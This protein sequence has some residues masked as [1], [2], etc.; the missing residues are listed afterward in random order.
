MSKEVVTVRGKPFQSKLAP[1]ESEIRELL[2]NE[3]KSTREISREM[4][5]RHQL[6]VSHNSVSSFIKTHKLS[7]RS[8]L[9]DVPAAKRGE[10]L[11]A[12]KAIW[13]HDSTAIEGNTLTIGD[14]MIVLKYGLTIN[15]KPLKD[16]QDVVSHANAVDLISKLVEKPKLEINDLFALHRLVIGEIPH[17]I[18]KPV[19]DFKREINGTYGEYK[20]KSV[21][22]AYAE[23]DETPKLMESWLIK[24]N[25]LLA[26]DLTEE[27]VLDAYLF[28]HTAFVR[29]HPFYDGNGRIARLI[30]NLPV[31]KAGFPPIVIASESRVNY[32]RSL[33]D[34]QH[35]VGVISLKNA[36]MLPSTPSLAAFRELVKASWAS[37][38]SL[39]SEASR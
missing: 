20:G 16:H 39:V 25:A 33:W 9:D 15:G 28:A 13:T 26:G 30:A 6:A 21:Y 37:T 31:L 2:L 11:Q 10:L 1:Y 4:L 19:G 8:F 32:I 23:V 34:Y 17:D 38:L 18:Y 27:E 14:T 12:I 22:M 5:L 7:R 35:E 24:F 36:D 3:G 29:I